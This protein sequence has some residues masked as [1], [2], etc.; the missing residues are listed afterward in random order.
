M[1]TIGERLKKLRGK[2]SGEEFA[3]RHHVHLQTLYRYERDERIPDI[4]FFQ[5]V[6]NESG[7]SLDWL[8]TG[9]G[10]MRREGL[11][12]AGITQTRELIQ[13]KTPGPYLPSETHLDTEPALRAETLTCF[14]CELVMIP[15]VEAK[16]SAGNGSWETS[17]DS[18]RRYAFRSDFLRRKGNPSTMVL[19]R[20]A[21]DSME[22]KIEHDDVVLV[23]TSQTVPHLGRMYAVAVEDL[24]YLKQVDAEP[25]KLILT[26][27]NSAYAPLEIDARG[28]QADGIRIIGRAIWVGRELG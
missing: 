26:S 1:N 22:P 15:L 12:F 20:V 19:M 27:A 5:S 9:E 16:L 24:V 8:V 4:N 21:G 14:D 3:A 17:G 13:G 23:D 7:V 10:K 18:D 11:Q 2:T 6:S 25:G 28:D